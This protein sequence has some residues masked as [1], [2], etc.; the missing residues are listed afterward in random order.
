MKKALAI[1]FIVAL[2]F[3]MYY[4]LAFQQLSYEIEAISIDEAGLLSASLTIFLRA[5][6]PNPLPLYLASTTFDLYING[7]YAGHGSTSSTTIEGHRYRTIQAP[8]TITYTGLSAAVVNIILIGG[9]VRMDIRGDA[10][11]FFIT[12]PFE[13]SDTVTLM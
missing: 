11:L 2:A 7:D 3:G 1:V 10:S 9:L 5:N 6:N 12:V 4:Y 8:I 13:I